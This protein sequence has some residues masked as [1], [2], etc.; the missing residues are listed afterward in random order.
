MK[1]VVKEKKNIINIIIQECKST[2]KQLIVLPDGQHNTTWL[3]HDYA[4]QIL[5][6][7]NDV[8]TQLYFDKKPDLVGVNISLLQLI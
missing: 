8:T 2:K 5:Q 7:F 1:F 4:N 3:S 6:R